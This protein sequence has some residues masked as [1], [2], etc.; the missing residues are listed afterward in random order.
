MHNLNKLKSEDEFS[1]FDKQFLNIGKSL[2]MVDQQNPY[3]NYY[4]ANYYQGKA[5][6]D[7]TSY[8]F[9]QIVNAKNF[10]SWWYTSLAK[11]WITENEKAADN[12]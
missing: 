4:M 3:A 2:L 12:I 7:S 6:D 5:L 10:E 1:E 11:K 8:Y 9:N